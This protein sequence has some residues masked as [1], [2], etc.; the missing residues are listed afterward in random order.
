MVLAVACAVATS[1]NIYG[2][3]IRFK[4]EGVYLAQAWAI[5]NMHALANYTYWYDHP[6][7]GWMQMATWATLTD[8]WDRWSS[9]STM[10]G[11]EFMVVIRVATTL[12]IF[13]LG[14][15][16]GMRR[17]WSV[18][19]ALIFV[20][21]PLAMYY[22]RLTLLDNVAMPW[23][24]ASFVLAWSPRR[25]WGASVGSA[26][27]FA[28]AVITKETLVL[29]APALLLALWSNYRRSSNRSFVWISFGLVLAMSTALYPLYAV[30]KSELTPGVG[31]VSLW[32]AIEWQ[33]SARKG[34]GSIFDPHSDARVLVDSW[35]SLDSWLPLCGLVAAA[36]LIADRRFR[37]I[38]VA[39]AIQAAMLLRQGYLPSMFVV[40][41]LP[42]LALSIAG[43][44]DRLWP[45]TTA[46][47][48]LRTAK[49]GARERLS[50]ASV[51]LRKVGAVTGA[52]LVAAFW[53]TAVS[54]ASD[55]W[56]NTLK[57]Q[58]TVDADAPQRQVIAWIRDNVP[59]DSV[60]VAEGEMWLDLHNAGFAGRNNVWVYKVDSDPAVTEQ[61]G[62]WQSI[63]YL[64]LSRVTLI[65]ESKKTMPMVFDAIEHSQRVA[66]FGQG[67]NAVQ[68]MKVNR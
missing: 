40:S 8:G 34:S 27:C 4:D 42:L 49:H 2:N 3:P 30:I 38:T 44:C 66:E 37:P 16:L 50:G 18:I 53:F 28:V 52:V 19:A 5:P 21:S 33:L 31:H 12:L 51:R 15:R 7:L 25:A 61:L 17:T 64:A 13:A 1:F 32:G 59:H 9:N 54:K 55:G 48:P 41:M 23:I 14:R 6:P 58:W 46:R 29:I 22:G 65:S 43:L 20:F 24:L 47:L 57:Y 35:L 60:V 62:R 10:A 36:L 68:I 26:L 39:V 11:R 67:D 63:D 56:I 45:S